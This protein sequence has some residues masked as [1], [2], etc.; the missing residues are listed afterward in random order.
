MVDTDLPTV[1]PDYV[2]TD[3]ED[4]MGP[5]MRAYF[6]GHLLKWRKELDD[7]NRETL[8][9]LQNDSLHVAEVLD[10]AS[11]ET[12][13]ALEL[14][15]RDRARKLIAKI[16]QAMRRIDTDDFGYCLDTG[17][18]IGVKRLLARPIATMT[19][20]AQEQKERR[21]KLHSDD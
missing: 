7:T 12:D 20:E 15:T 14:R 10:R 19:V 4:Y 13:K 17:E 16:D 11:I 5:M 3:D 6:R 8:E 9:S 18:P 1:A 21:E 2:P